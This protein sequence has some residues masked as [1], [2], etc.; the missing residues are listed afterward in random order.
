MERA[1]DPEV[2]KYFRKIM[3]TVSVG[4]SWLLSAMTAGIYF[5]LAY[6][7]PVIYLI[8]YWVIVLVTLVLLIRYFYRTWRKGSVKRET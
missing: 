5:R 2:T 7:R 4:L 3:N 6:D 8:I 1:W